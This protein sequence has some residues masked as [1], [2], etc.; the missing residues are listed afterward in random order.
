[1]SQLGF[2]L[3]MCRSS[4][5]SCILATLRFGLKLNDTCPSDCDFEGWS[6]PNEFCLEFN[7]MCDRF[8]DRP[9]S[10]DDSSKSL[11]SSSSSSFLWRLPSRVLYFGD[12]NIFAGTGLILASKITSSLRSKSTLDSPTDGMIRDELPLS[13]VGERSSSTLPRPHGC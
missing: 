3:C 8:F 10:S 11:V 1:M 5:F 13:S 6:L 7:P 12:L 4:S 2:S 9:F